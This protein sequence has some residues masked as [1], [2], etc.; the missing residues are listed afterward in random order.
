MCESQPNGV[1][2]GDPSIIGV[3]KDL[4]G[5]GTFEAALLVADLVIPDLPPATPSDSAL[6]YD[7]RGGPIQPVDPTLAGRLASIPTFPDVTRY[8]QDPRGDP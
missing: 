3:I 5:G 6:A 7:R 1:D 8:H 4:Q 2:D